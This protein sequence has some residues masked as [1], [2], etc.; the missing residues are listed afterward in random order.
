MTREVET[1]IEELRVRLEE[2]SYAYYVLADLRASDAEYD[3]LF[4]KLQRLEAEYPQYDREDSPSRKVG[5]PPLE[6]F[7]PHRHVVPMLSLAN[8]HNE[9]DIR[10]FDRR[11]LKSLGRD[12]STEGNARPVAYTLEPK[13]DGVGIS[14]T[15]EAGSLVLASTRGDGTTGEN[16]T[17]NA[18][19]INSVPLRLRGPKS[20]HPEFVEIRGEVFVEKSRFDAFNADRSEEEGRYANPRNF[21]SG[22]LRQLDSSIT[23]ARPLDA[24]FYSVGELR[25]IKI[26][27]Q[28]ELFQRLDTWGL[29]Y[30][31]SQLAFCPTIDDVVKAH[32]KLESIRDELPYE[33]DG[34]VIKVDDEELR[35]ILGFRSRNPRWAVAVKFKSREASTRLLGVDVSIG[36]TGALTPVARLEPVP[37]G[38]VTIS[39]ASLHNYDEIE[40]LDLRLGDRVLVERAG[41][42]IP[43]VTKVLTAERTGAE[44]KIEAPT[45]CPICGTPSQRDAEKVVLRCPNAVCP[46]RI[47][48]GL[49]HF[50]AKN[51]LDIDGLG[52]KLVIQLVDEGLVTTY[53]DIFGLSL[54][55]LLPLERMGATSAENLL[56]AIEKA[57]S[58]TLSR[59]LFGLGIRHVGASVAEI[60]ARHLKTLEGLLA[61]NYE[62]LEA[63]HEVGEKAAAAVAEFAGDDDN[64]AMIEA[65]IAAGIKTKVEEV[66]HGGAFAGLTFCVTGTLPTL[67]R[68]EA[69]N[70]IK[71][72][73]GKPVSAVSKKTDFLVAGE[74]AGSKLK[75]A[76]GYGLKI[77]DEAA[78][79]KLAEG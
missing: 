64:R 21:A 63:I 58:T 5:A 69:Q 68:Q 37:I 60:L 46:A 35:Q 77:L 25:G 34:T 65:L 7:Q 47:K 45:Q 18:K 29:K 49:I 40:R 75:K 28:A 55:Q 56:A 42:V 59:V 44:S 24:F 48:G 66:S 9:E 27:S 4:A 74:K 8:A 1:I 67:S 61:A 11:V 32:Q 10:D 22:S 57:K 62:D 6:S 51:A 54:D 38:G 53:P 26:K 13:I 14:L 39:N 30:A 12:E 23:A 52:E 71:K 50:V 31:K 20:E 15:Y 73:G 19:T 3:D 72:N 33:I 79:L 43:K 17:L 70:F 16:I 78:L 2:L 41:D 36:R 76:E